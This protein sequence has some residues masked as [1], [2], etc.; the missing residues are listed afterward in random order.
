MEQYLRE[1]FSA[2]VIAAGI[3]MAYV[4][5]RAKMNGGQK[6]KNSELVKPA[7]LVGLLVYFIISQGQGY[8]QD[9]AVKAPF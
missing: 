9:P 7:F 6:L 8:S 3:T 4:F 5:G 2:A 1:P